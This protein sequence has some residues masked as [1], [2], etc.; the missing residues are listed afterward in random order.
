MK[1]HPTPA[2]YQPH[3][4]GVSRTNEETEA[5]MNLPLTTRKD[6]RDWDM[7][8]SGQVVTPITAILCGL[9]GNCPLGRDGEGLLQEL[10]CGVGAEGKQR[11]G[12][13]A[14]M[15]G[16][17]AAVMVLPCESMSGPWVAH[18]QLRTAG[19]I[20]VEGAGCGEPGGAWHGCSGV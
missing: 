8:L 4:V 12:D 17:E 15:P 7:G 10:N 1:D 20:C 14:W 18:G 9:I 11:G 13:K 3:E 19:I 16:Q 2:L 5:G 6:G